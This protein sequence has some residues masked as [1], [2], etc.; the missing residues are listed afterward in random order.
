MCLAIHCVSSCALCLATHCVSSYTLCLA[1]HCGSSYTC[2]PLKGQDCCN[3]TDCLHAMCRV[4]CVASRHTEHTVHISSVQY[5]H[6]DV[7]SQKVN[8]IDT[9]LLIVLDIFHWLTRSCYLFILCHISTATYCY[10]YT[11]ALCQVSIADERSMF[12]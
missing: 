5:K 7:D 3:E 10:V 4:S 2:I 6:C 8:Y 11:Y 9:I 1:I 12:L